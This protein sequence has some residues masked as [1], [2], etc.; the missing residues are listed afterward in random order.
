[1][2]SILL[3]SRPARAALLLGAALSL[4]ACRRRP[5][6]PPAPVDLGL[7]H[8]VV[9]LPTSVQLSRADS[10]R[11]DTATH[12]VVDADASAETERIAGVLAEMLAPA[13]HAG[14]MRAPSESVPAKAMLLR[15]DP[16]RTE[17]GEEGYELTVQPSRVTL[18]AGN[19]HG[20]F[21][22]V[23]TIRQLL[24]SSIEHPAAMGRRLWIP[25]GR[26]VDIPRFAWRG[27]MLDVSRHFLPAEDVKRYIDVLALYKLN[28]LH[29]HLAD[30]QGWR[31][32]IRSWPNLAYHGGSTQVGGGAG[33]YYTQEAFADLVA[34]A[35]DRYV[36]IVPEIDMPSHI[37]AA[38]SSY[39]ELNCDGVAPPLYTGTEVGFSLI[40]VERDTVYRFIG[41][42]VREI[43]ALVPTPWFHIGGDEV[44][45][46]AHPQ[47]VAFIERVQGIVDSLG[48]T[49]IGWGEIAPAK[50]DPRTIVQHWV[51]DS[52]AV[53][54][55]RGGK[56]IMSPASQAYLDMKFDSSTVLGL[57]WAGIHDVRDIYDWDPAQRIAGVPESAVLGV[58]G[59]LW[60]ETLVKL[61]D[62]EYMA[63]PRLVA[64]AEVGW[65]RQASRDWTEFRR[66]LGAQGPR[67]QALGVNFYRSPQVPWMR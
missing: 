41:D 48:K 13:A 58:E 33:G 5:V 63:F 8:G 14:V 11:V 37:N 23:Q 50:L 43:G 32:E 38:L 44:K 21:Y 62:Y 65:S 53:H 39:P 9:P 24:P 7:V 60:A 15:V 4:G 6:T 20:L 19:P 31:I 59:P 46:L 18:V 26:V 25:T 47:Y 12:V 30:D 64:L 29:L 42:V 16:A 1:M 54:A 61:D 56:I 3:A 51:N 66:R 52:S 2:R 10:F 45:K 49:M 35:R 55:A 40:C 28:R 57:Q 36:T 34:Y 22:G 27:G 67:L 17:L